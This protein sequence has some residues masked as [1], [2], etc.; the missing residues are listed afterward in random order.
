M[1][2]A[3]RPP[4]DRGHHSRWARQ[5]SSMF[6]AAAHEAASVAGPGQV[7]LPATCRPRLHR[8]RQ[9]SRR[10]AFRRHRL[11]RALLRPEQPLP[12]PSLPGSRP[13]RAAP[14]THRPRSAARRRDG[15]HRRRRLLQPVGPWQSPTQ[16]PAGLPSPPRQQASSSVPDRSRRRDGRSRPLRRR[17]RQAVSS[18]PAG[19][20]ITQ[21]RRRQPGQRRR[22]KLSSLPSS[23]SPRASN[24][25]ARQRTRRTSP[26]QRLP[27]NANRRSSPEA[28]AAS[29]PSISPRND[30]PTTSATGRSPHLPSLFLTSHDL[31]FDTP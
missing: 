5:A 15:S 26:S 17:R 21:H 10:S 14:R 11:P 6:P 12:L 9:L 23:A 28:L 30:T 22:R 8:Q 7:R 29:L 2:A 20:R 1:T 24:S 19:C 3:D 18:R 16:R 13:A 25:T 31:P 4:L 27:G